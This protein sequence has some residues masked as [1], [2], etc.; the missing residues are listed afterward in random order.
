MRVSSAK[1][2]ELKRAGKWNAQLRELVKEKSGAY[3]VRSTLTDEFL[4]VGESHSGQLWKTLTRHFHARESFRREGRDGAPTRWTYGRPDLVE[5]SVWITRADQAV[6]VQDRL[7]ERFLPTYNVVIPAGMADREEGSD[8]EE[9][10][11]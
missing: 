1:W 8:A 4:Y 6:S 7:I 9:A 11:F 5:V 10:P 2:L 3:V